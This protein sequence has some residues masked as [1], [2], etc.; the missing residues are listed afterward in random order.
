MKKSMWRL[1]AC[2]F[3]LV[4]M[5]VLASDSDRE[6]QEVFSR[7]LETHGDSAVRVSFVIVSAYGGQEQRQESSVTGM[8]VDSAGLVLVPKLVVEPSF[9]GMAQL[10]AEQQ[11]A[12]KLESRDFRV[13]FPGQDQPFQAEALTSDADQGIAW[14]RIIDPDPKLM[15]AI[16]LKHRAEGKPGMAYYVIER[17]EDR[18][19]NAPLVSWGVLQG[20]IL[21]PQ[22][23]FI[24]TGA[25]GLAFNAE[26][27]VL[28]FVSMDF[29]TGE[30]GLSSSRTNPRM[31]LTS[32]TRL[33][34]ATQRAKSLL[35]SE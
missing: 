23:A 26:G 22:S 2:V 15:K 4:A 33:A 25:A 21:V 20:E 24:G 8:I 5:P 18:Y 34:S 9:P 13:H 14:L 29:D 30:S 3:A 31:M 12:F 7:L 10:S 27:Q 32:S 28:G 16:N 35:D 19:G 17:L 1:L 11:M 6:T